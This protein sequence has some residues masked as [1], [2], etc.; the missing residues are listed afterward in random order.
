MPRSNVKDNPDFIGTKKNLC[1]RRR[2][3]SKPVK[4]DDITFKKG[5]LKNRTTCKGMKFLRVRPKTINLEPFFLFSG[6]H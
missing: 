4:S 1:L 5:S 3:R 2:I 6:Q